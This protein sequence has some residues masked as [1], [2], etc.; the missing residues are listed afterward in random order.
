MELPQ[1]TRSS[2]SSRSS[3]V[4]AASW[5]HDHLEKHIKPIPVPIR[6]SF[7]PW[8]LL[9][10]HIEAQQPRS[11]HLWSYI[12]QHL[13]TDE[14]NFAQVETW[15]LFALLAVL[16]LGRSARQ[17]C[18]I[19]QKIQGSSQHD[20]NQSAREDSQQLDSAW[21][22]HLHMSTIKPHKQPE[23]W[24]CCSSKSDVFLTV[25][26]VHTVCR[27]SVKMKLPTQE[28]TIITA[29]CY[30]MFIVPLWHSSVAL[31]LWA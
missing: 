29:R 11:D 10:K 31:Q 2:H 27:Y 21:F 13:Q 8:H 23:G 24:S 26:T 15:T 19:Y 25:Y 14:A 6:V 1:Q 17:T 18:L 30:E 9:F 28:G 22:H 16:P 5:A 7:V 20:G 3:Q 12:E 4:I